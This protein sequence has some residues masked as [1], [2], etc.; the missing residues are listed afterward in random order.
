MLHVILDN[1]FGTLAHNGSARSLLLKK[2]T[3]ELRYVRAV[4]CLAP[5]CC[6]C[7]GKQRFAW[8]QLV[9][10]ELTA[11]AG[12]SLGAA[13]P[14]WLCLKIG[15]RLRKQAASRRMLGVS[16][17]LTAIALLHWQTY[18]GGNVNAAVGLLFLQGAAMLIARRNCTSV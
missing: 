15:L 11:A 18:S 2:K 8:P 6:S 5:R 10:L 1:G 12:A 7:L 14:V 3:H 4:A 16:P 17:V 9:L 13:D